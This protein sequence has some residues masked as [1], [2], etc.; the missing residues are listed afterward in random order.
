MDL[1]PIVVRPNGEIKRVSIRDAIRIKS[2]ISAHSTD[3]EV[4]NVLGECQQ[5]CPSVFRHTR[6]YHALESYRRANRVCEVAKSEILKAIG[7]YHVFTIRDPEFEEVCQ[8]H[9]YNPASLAGTLVKYG[10]ME[11]VGFRRNPN[12]KSKNSK[13]RTYQI[14][15]QR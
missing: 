9:G 1:Q 13:I 14:L 6:Q 8:R 12:T 3:K 7:Y 10:F 15:P 2:Q 5:P 4:S 11:I